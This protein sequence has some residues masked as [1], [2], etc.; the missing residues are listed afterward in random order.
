MTKKINGKPVSQNYKSYI[1]EVLLSLPFK[2]IDFIDHKKISKLLNS[3]NSVNY[4]KMFRYLQ[5]YILINKF[6][7]FKNENL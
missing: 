1:E 2:N 5:I 7:E 4:K 3:N 6:N